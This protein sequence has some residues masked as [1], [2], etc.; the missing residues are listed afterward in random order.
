MRAADFGAIYPAVGAGQLPGDSR[1]V[2]AA[3]ERPGGYEVAAP[4]DACRRRTNRHRQV[5]LP[6]IV[7]D[8][9]PATRDQT[10]QPV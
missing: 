3:G 7:G 5:H 2:Q 6:G 9:Q 8:E 10:G 4:V 1:A